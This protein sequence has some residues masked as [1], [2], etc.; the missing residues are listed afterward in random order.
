MTLEVLFLFS[1]QIVFPPPWVYIDYSECPKRGIKKLL[2][3]LA[4]HCAPDNASL[5][6]AQEW[7][8]ALVVFLRIPY[9][10]GLCPLP[11]PV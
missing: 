11:V 6:P 8:L 4:F 10:F 9:P 7:S 3:K 1:A 5:K 2:K